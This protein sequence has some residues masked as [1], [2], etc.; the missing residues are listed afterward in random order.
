MTEFISVMVVGAKYL[1][2]HTRKHI[3][4]QKHPLKFIQQQP[5]TDVT[6]S[7]S[8]TYVQSDSSFH[9]LD[10][11]LCVEDR[12]RQEKHFTLSAPDNSA[13]K[14]GSTDSRWSV[15]SGAFRLL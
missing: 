11:R 8:L 5:L 2:Q 3:D 7:Q 15:L 4:F 12:K 13:A 9:P 1:N 6:H 10:S 14:W